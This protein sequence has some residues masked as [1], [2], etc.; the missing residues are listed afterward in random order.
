[1]NSVSPLNPFLDGDPLV[2][3]LNRAVLV[4]LPGVPVPDEML[5][6][7]GYQLLS[8]QTLQDEIAASALAIGLDPHA[9]DLIRAFDASLAIPPMHPAATRIAQNYGE[10]L[11]YFL[12][13]LRRGDAPNRAARPQWT[14][15]HWEFWAQVPR[16]VVGGGMM[17]GNLGRLAVKTAYALLAAYRANLTLDLSPYAAHLPLVGL[18]R[19][20]PSD[21]TRAL[22]LDFGQTSV[23]RGLAM[24][25]DGMLL[26]L[27]V[28]PNAPSVC[29]ELFKPEHT[30]DE[31][32]ERWRAMQ[33]I[34]AVSWERVPLENRSTIAVGIC[35]SSYL[36]NG[37]PAPGDLGCYAVLGRLA[38]NLEIFMRDELTTRLGM[39]IPFYLMHDGAA[40]SC[41]Y[42]G[43]PNCVVLTL[44]T[45]IGNGFPPPAEAA[46]PLD[47]QFRVI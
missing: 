46:W 24:Y 4:A 39:P 44:D 34:I 47:P 22:V 32:R 16:V 7:T 3:S 42:A 12:L 31:L 37:Q 28:W 9:P 29:T 21:V 20:A 19:A 45:A 10:R 40:A 43:D 25:D 18:A 38:P 36:Y 6:K 5:G 2:R 27:D 26:R 14:D 11:G 13:M 15:A 17:S 8:A 30:L 35:I 23:K 41:A 1:M 33:E